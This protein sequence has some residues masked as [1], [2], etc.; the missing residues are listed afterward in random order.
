MNHKFA[1]LFLLSFSV[2]LSSLSA[3]KIYSC[4]NKYDADFRVFV[5][6]NKY[7][8]D[9]LVYKV[10]NKYDAEGNNGLWF[11]EENRYDANK[12][13]FFS[14]DKYDADL[15]IFFTDNK[16]DAGWRIRTKMYLL[17]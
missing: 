11:F 17:Y 12:T 8:A 16:Y 4:D 9:L 7:D 14:E 13:I 3:Q 10:A 1:F 5:V 15:L 6:E 2:W